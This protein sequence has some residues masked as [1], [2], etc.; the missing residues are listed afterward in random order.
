MRYKEL[1]GIIFKCELTETESETG[2][3]FV[4]GPVGLSSHELSLDQVPD[5]QYSQKLVIPQTVD[6]LRTP[7]PSSHPGSFLF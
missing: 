2:Q 1:D 7:G 3:A 5:G 4:T 6:F